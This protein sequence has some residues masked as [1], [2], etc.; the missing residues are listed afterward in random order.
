M[1]EFTGW[2]LD[3]YEDAQDGVRVWVLG[4]DGQR[5]CLRHTFP[6]TFYAAGPPER[7]REAWRY[8]RTQ[9]ER[10]RLERLQRDDL[11]SGP[12]TVLAVQ[13]GSPAIQWGVFQGLA[14]RFPDL[15]YYDA[16][17]PLALRFGA[18]YEVFPL[19]RCRVTA[20]ADD[21][22]LHIAALDSR[23]E[24]DPSPPPLRILTIAPDQD[25]FHA[26]PA[27]LVVHTGRLVYRLA[28]EPPR[29]LLVSLG[30]ILRR[31]DPDLLL[32]NW[33]DTWLFPHLFKLSKACGI[34]FNP[35][36]DPERAALQIK[37]RSFFTYGQVVYRGQQTHLYGRWHIDQLNAM[38]Y[39]EY[40]L[41]GVLEQARV[42]GLPVQEI[43]RKS[44]GS[45]ITAMQMQTALRRG[46][47]VPYQKQEAEQFKSALDLIQADSGGLVYQPLVGL[48]E[49]VA[50][51]DFVSMYPS[52][53]AHF[54]ISPETVGVYGQEAQPIPQIGIRVKQ[55]PLG[56][57]PE[58]L[59]PLLDM[60]LAIKGR[61]AA[62]ERHDCRYGPYKA[63]ASALKW[64]L[65]VCFGYLGYKN[66]RFG[67]IESHQAVTAYSREIL[68]QAKE[69][70]EELGFTVLHMYVDGLWVQKPGHSKAIDFQPLLEA[71][72]SKT[73]LPIALEGVYR[74]VMF[75]P[76]RVDARL[77]VANR[78][79]GV[80]QDGSIKMRGIEARRH[81]SA[82]FVAATQLQ[83]L[84]RM[85]QA[86]DAASLAGCLPDILALLR[87]R[88]ADLRLGR[89]PLERLLVSQT[90]SRELAEY[91]TPSPAARAAAQLEAHGKRLRPGQRIRFVYILGK[92]GVRA[93]DLPAPPDP[94]TVD[95]KVYQKLLLRAAASALAPLGLDEAQIELRLR[96]YTLP[97]MLLRGR[98]REKIN[99]QG[100]KT[101]SLRAE[102][103]ERTARREEEI[104][105]L[106]V[107]S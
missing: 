63:R 36:R 62:L 1:S 95:V 44:P 87:R 22:L 54:N 39:G 106:R 76:S 24:L 85:A 4:E 14:Q 3:L 94:A 41:Q 2:L 97:E 40:R 23:W 102:N 45:G 84:E 12:K 48:H 25:P 69:T 28:L 57:V 17:I 35:N 105:A 68:L 70:A 100:A 61:L 81:D 107:G 72:A 11:F 42:T 82:E 8:L 16:D 77:P 51:I 7:L 21:R 74:W 101:P 59:Q 104:T 90:L 47:L 19:A 15:D 73:R 29:P 13:V 67:R 6:I 10:V 49:H 99:R 98:G 80:F 30:A 27:H 83:M 65:V 64:L 92:P 5:R 56:L 66:A 52:I 46:V 60:R 32:T 88:M 38:M 75:L 55:E 18:A 78:Y 86:P 43:A 71:V 26:A 31:H 93:W 58:T 34:P 96:G 89:V 79:F 9:P 33:G 103:N 50:E 37:E 53:M 91:R 20:G